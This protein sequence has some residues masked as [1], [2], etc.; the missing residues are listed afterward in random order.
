MLSFYNIRKVIAIQASRSLEIGSFSAM[1]CMFYNVMNV[2][3]I[4][5]LFNPNFDVLLFDLN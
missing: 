5:D 2:G 4:C 3:E 1:L